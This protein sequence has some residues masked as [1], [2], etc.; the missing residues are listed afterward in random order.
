MPSARHLNSVPK[1]LNA[2]FK[3]AL[4]GCGGLCGWVAVP[5]DGAFVIA[6]GTDPT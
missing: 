3:P 5:R 1:P 4:L 2:A 6:L